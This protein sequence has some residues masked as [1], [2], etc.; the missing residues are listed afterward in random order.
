MHRRLSPSTDCGSSRCGQVS[1]GRCSGSGLASAPF[2]AP[3][4]VPSLASSSRPGFPASLIQGPSLTYGRAAGRLSASSAGRESYIDHSQRIP[5]TTT[6][7]NSN[8][9]SCPDHNYLGISF[10][11]RLPSCLSL[12]DHRRRLASWTS[13]ARYQSHRCLPVALACC[14]IQG[15]WQSQRHCRESP[16]LP[17]SQSRPAQQPT[18]TSNSFLCLIGQYLFLQDRCRR[19]QT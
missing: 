4:V 14:I 19:H 1:G 10:G 7:M 11:I 17:P 16:S 13:G 3:A 12:S 2:A 6:M 8:S 18:H 5:S 9:P 15:L